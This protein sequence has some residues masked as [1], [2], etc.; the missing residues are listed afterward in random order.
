M[1]NRRRAPTTEPWTGPERRVQPHNGTDPLERLEACVAGDPCFSPSD[2]AVIHDMIAAYRGWQALG[3]ATKWIILVL[4][5]I[6]GAVVALNNLTDGVAKW[7][8]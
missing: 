2:A 6:S 4:A 7:F 8:R 1:R 5:A 3:K